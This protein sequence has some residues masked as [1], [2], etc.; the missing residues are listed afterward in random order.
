MA[1][2]AITKKPSRLMP[3]VA[4]LC[5]AVYGGQRMDEWE[6]RKLIEIE[7]GAEPL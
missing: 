2:I 1:S 5:V 4:F 3:I 7:V 6:Q